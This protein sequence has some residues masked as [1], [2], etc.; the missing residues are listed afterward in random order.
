MKASTKLALQFYKI[1]FMGYNDNSRWTVG[2]TLGIFAKNLD[3]LAN[4]I[5]QT[6]ENRFWGKYQEQA[7][8]TIKRL[9]IAPNTQYINKIFDLKS[10]VL[11]FH[12]EAL[13]IETQQKYYDNVWVRILPYENYQKISCIKLYKDYQ[14][15]YSLDRYGNYLVK[16]QVKQAKK[17]YDERGFIKSWEPPR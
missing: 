5:I 7:N 13:G 6:Y 11:S 8:L 1:Q 16:G 2:W 12:I 4:K 9:E 15:G 10:S 17:N 14:F 3:N